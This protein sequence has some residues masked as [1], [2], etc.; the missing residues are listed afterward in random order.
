MTMYIISVLLWSRKSE[1]TFTSKYHLV[2]VA[3]AAYTDH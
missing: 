1:I 2:N 3:F